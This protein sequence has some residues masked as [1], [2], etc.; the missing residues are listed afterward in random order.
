MGANVAP[1]GHGVQAFGVM[2]ASGGM[3]PPASHPEPYFPQGTGWHYSNTGYVLR[4][5]IIQEIAT[6]EVSSP[7]TLSSVALTA[8]M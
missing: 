4:G 8:R 2:A 5:M 7:D 3:D 1:H 6:S